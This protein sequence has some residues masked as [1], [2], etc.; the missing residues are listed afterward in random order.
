MAVFCVSSSWYRRLVWCFR[1]LYFLVMLTCFLNYMYTQMLKKVTELAP[2]A[3]ERITTSP[4][5]Y[6]F[7][8][9]SLLSRDG[10]EFSH[11]ELWINSDND[12]WVDLPLIGNT[13]LTFG[14]GRNSAVAVG[15]IV[16]L[17]LPCD[18]SKAVASCSRG[19]RATFVRQFQGKFGSSR[20]L[21]SCAP[22]AYCADIVRLPCNCFA[23]W[24]HRPKIVKKMNTENSSYDVVAALRP[25][26]S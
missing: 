26:V 14:T 16:F 21:T 5:G 7:S 25:C 24:K 1:L 3:T 10:I 11:S 18:K 13:I 19:Y 23:T 9:C 6:F 17:R 2:T 15:F 8:R 4:S 22:Y 12:G 20:S